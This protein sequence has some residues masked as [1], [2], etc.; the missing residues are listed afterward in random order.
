MDPLFAEYFTGISLT[1][2]LETDVDRLLRPRGFLRVAAHLPRVAAQAAALAEQYGA[3]PH[4]AARAGWLHDISVIIPNH[5]RVALAQQLG[6]AVLPEEETLP[7]IL[8]QKLSA[9]MAGSCF[10]IKTP[11]VAAAIRCHTT[12][13]AGAGPLEKILFVADKIAWDQDGTP[14]YLAEIEAAAAQSL[15]DACRVYLRW[16]WQRR[17]TL[18]VLHPWLVEACGELGIIRKW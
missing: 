5:R 7:M 12:L 15:D 2:D 9:V 1:G 18:P 3:D 4:A 13:R 16:L 10:G 17:E 8:H 11:A 6:L 14:P